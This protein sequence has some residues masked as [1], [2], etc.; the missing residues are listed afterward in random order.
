MSFD[1]RIH[2]SN[3]LSSPLMEYYKLTQAAKFVKFYL[4]GKRIFKKITKESVK[5]NSQERSQEFVHILTDN[6]KS[7]SV[8]FWRGYRVTK[9]LCVSDNM[10]AHL[11]GVN[12]PFKEKLSHGT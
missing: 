3:R 5:S 7:T 12:R 1:M 4:L 8:A 9:G 10:A 6:M 11:N 2:P